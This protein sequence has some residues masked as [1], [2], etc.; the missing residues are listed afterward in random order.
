MT[1]VAGF[2]SSDLMLLCSDMEEGDGYSKKRVNKIVH[3]DGNGWQADIG[4]SGPSAILDLTF[5]KLKKE[6]MACGDDL[7]IEHQEIIRSVLQQM[8]EQYI[9]PSKARDYSIDLLV[10]MKF[11]NLDEFCLYKTQEYIP[12]PIEEFSCIGLGAVLGN[13]FASLLHE[14]SLTRT[15]MMY[16]GAFII[17]E[18]RDFVSDCGKGTQMEITMRDGRH[19]SI[20]PELF[21]GFD[22]GDIPDRR[23][24]ADWFWEGATGWEYSDNYF[25]AWN[26]GDLMLSELMGKKWKDELFKVP[27][28]L[29][30]K[31]G[32]ENDK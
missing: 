2:L 11:K 10:G 9:W 27:E 25:E 16:M 31:P 21:E 6:F 30:P 18:V 26:N 22:G 19:Y 12:Q 28:N 17:Q 32:G 7:A 15:Q 3:I 14:P 5:K 1:I 20:P 13:Y 4:G 24:I 8:Y 23:G 29:P